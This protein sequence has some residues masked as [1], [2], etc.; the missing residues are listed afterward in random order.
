MNFEDD[1]LYDYQK[2]AIEDLEDKG[3][4]GLILQGGVG[5]GKSRTG[6]YW[7]FKANKGCINGSSYI[8]MKNPKDLYIIT[9]AHKRDTLDWQLEMIPFAMYVGRSKKEIYSN[10]IVV[11][12]WQNIKKY[13]NV[14]DSY[15]I[16]DEDHVVS[17]GAWADS[18]IKI[19]RGGNKW[20]VMTATPADQWKEYGP[21]FV[22]CGFYKHKTAFN[23]EHIIWDPWSKFPKVK[24]YMNTGKLIRLRKRITVQIHYTHNIDILEK[25]ILCN[26]DKTKYDFVLRERYDIWKDEPYQNAGGLCY[27]LRRVCNSDLSR[28]EVLNE[29]FDKHHKLI[30]FY[31]YDYE[32][33]L[34]K[35]WGSQLIEN[36]GDDIIV[37]ELNGHR[38]GELPS[39]DRWVYLCQYN[40][41][42]EAWNCISTNVIVFYSQT[43]SYK[44]LIQAKGRIDR[45]N[46]P[47]S[48]LYYYHL[49]SRS[50]IDISIKKNLS[51]KK[52][53]NEGKYLKDLGVEFVN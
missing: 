16:F 24:G 3:N 53:F 18:F 11:D 1:F 19:A 41:A 9:T 22:A 33:E 7:Y 26:Y 15:F 34:L 27:G 8:P 31:N 36:E 10:N 4:S 28:F 35:L 51:R 29:L 37:D 52:K 30:I 43:Y 6:L 42:A 17:F 39:G 49:L 25:P 12:S 13:E 38:H 45:N 47:F 48:K 50:P 20:I 2:K 23:N 32:L 21:I 40:S 5:C 46:T 44:T 14:V